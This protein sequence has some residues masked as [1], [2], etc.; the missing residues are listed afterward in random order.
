MFIT[1]YF[2]T[3]FQNIYEI[4]ILKLI[5]LTNFAGKDNKNIQRQPIGRLPQK[6]I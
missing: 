1:Q 6:I 3:G 5:I 2:E 4:S